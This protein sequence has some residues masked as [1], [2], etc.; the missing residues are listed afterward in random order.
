MVW[1]KKNLSVLVPCH[2]S[3]PQPTTIHFCTLGCK[4]LLS[5]EDTASLSA[6]L[7]SCSLL[8]LGILEILSDPQA[9]KKISSCSHSGLRQDLSGSL[10]LNMDW[11]FCQHSCGSLCLAPAPSSRQMLLSITAFSLH[12]TLPGHMG[13]DPREDHETENNSPG[14][15]QTWRDRNEM[16]EAPGRDCGTCPW[17]PPWVHGRSWGP[18]YSSGQ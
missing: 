1:E 11:L 2:T 8:A 13:Y 10:I 5:V 17:G 7:D 6:S 14:D 9:L 3:H 15:G 16:T 4:P 12:C 18:D